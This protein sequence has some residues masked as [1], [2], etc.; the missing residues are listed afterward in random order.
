MALP[1]EYPAETC[2]VARS[3]EIVGERWTLLIMRDAFYGTRRF[4]DF[5]A[6]LGVPKAVLAERLAMLV[7]QG[8]LTKATGVYELTTKGRRL[9]PVIWSMITWGNENYLDKTSRRTYR[10]AECGGV[11]G[12][13]RVCGRCAQVPDVSDLVAHPPRHPRDPR[14]DD[15]VSR[16]LA[17]PHRLLEPI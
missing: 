15:S 1:R 5:H 9:W 6:H 11:I 12:Q 4:S 8:V 3:L 7:T 16:A 14:R 17:R 10:H 13:D 2:P